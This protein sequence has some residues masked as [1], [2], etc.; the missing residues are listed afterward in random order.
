[1]RIPLHGT[2]DKEKIIDLH[3]RMAEL[4]PK[5]FRTPSNKKK[6]KPK[7]TRLEKMAK[8]VYGK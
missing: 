4:N 7:P 5:G 8:E 1:M 6:K 2:K 3:M